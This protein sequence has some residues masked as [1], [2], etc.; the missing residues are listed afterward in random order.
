MTHTPLLF[1]LREGPLSI[2]P[3][4]ADVMDFSLPPPREEIRMAD[5]YPSLINFD[6]ELPPAEEVALTRGSPL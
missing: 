4:V 1:P 2:L 3:S 6:D 5:L